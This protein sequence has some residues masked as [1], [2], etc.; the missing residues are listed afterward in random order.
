LTPPQLIH[1]FARKDL[2]RE[3]TGAVRPGTT[4]MRVRPAQRS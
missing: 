2:R 4:L 3:Q 1:R